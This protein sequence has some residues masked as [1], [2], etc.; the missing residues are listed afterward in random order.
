MRRPFPLLGTGA[1]GFLSPMRL[2]FGDKSR[3]TP[4]QGLCAPPNIFRGGASA[5]GPV[6][7]RRRHTSR[8]KDHRPSQLVFLLRG[9]GYQGKDH[10][11]PCTEFVKYSVDKHKK[12][13]VLRRGLTHLM[14]EEMATKTV[15][16]RR[17]CDRTLCSSCDWTRRST[18]AWR[19][20][21]R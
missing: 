21:I 4:T 1:D 18:H 13:P 15:R 20:G 14:R 19:S 11:T 6:G 2:H 12:A 8:I 17:R 9:S 5:G 10:Y 7:R 16:V 3:V